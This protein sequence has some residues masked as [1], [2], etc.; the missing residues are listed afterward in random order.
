M[1]VF[2]GR[3][4]WC[5]VMTWYKF[6]S[7]GL[8]PRFGELW[9]AA[10][11]IAIFALF[12]LCKLLRFKS[13]PSYAMSPDA[14]RQPIALGDVPQTLRPNL[15]SRIDSCARRGYQ[16][17]EV[18]QEPLLGHA[19]RYR[20]ILLREDGAAWVI[21]EVMRILTSVFAMCSVDSLV[22]DGTIIS[23]ND[24]LPSS[25][26]LPEF[27]IVHLPGASIEELLS[28]HDERLGNLEER[29]LCR[30]NPDSVAAHVNGIGR[31]ALVTLVANGELVPLTSVELTKLSSVQSEQGE[32]T[33]APKEQVEPRVVSAGDNPYSAPREA[34]VVEGAALEVVPR[35]GCRTFLYLGCVV[36]T[37]LCAWNVWEVFRH[38]ASFSA[39]V[40]AIFISGLEA[41]GL[42]SVLAWL[43]QKKVP[44]RDHGP[45]E[46][47]R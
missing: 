28:R 46:S 15:E 4:Q 7:D 45:A 29:R 43:T 13:W 19:A 30:M 41:I 1:A 16:I 20:V 34:A 47:S 37:C 24:S 26:G 38:E 8:P 27:D 17:V 36:F 39:V 5:G 2:R 21:C 22:D 6:R 14:P 33:V 18:S 10:P 44:A 32:T 11:N 12:A 3:S 23:T 40:R 31:R 9:R 35:F 42:I 25:D